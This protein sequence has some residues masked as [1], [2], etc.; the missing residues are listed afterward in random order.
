MAALRTAARVLQVS[1]F[2]A[3]KQCDVDQFACA[4]PA[5]DGW[6]H[7]VVA[8]IKSGASLRCGISN[9]PMS[10]RGIAAGLLVVPRTELQSID[11]FFNHAQMDSEPLQV[12]FEWACNLE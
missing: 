8:R 6:Q 11:V 5:R 1:T 7:S 9:Q 10:A 12:D 3:A 4:A 2:T